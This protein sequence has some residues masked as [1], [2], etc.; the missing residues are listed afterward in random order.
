VEEAKALGVP[1]VLSDIPVHRE[2]CSEDEAQFF[3]PDDS[4]ALALCMERVLSDAGGREGDRR[5]MDAAL[6]KHRV[7]M[8]VFAR[9]YQSI[10]NEL[11]RGQ[12]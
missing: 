8:L 4:G 10:V 1:M 5:Y 9:T 11:V 2:Q 6:E 3:S 7:R 12:K